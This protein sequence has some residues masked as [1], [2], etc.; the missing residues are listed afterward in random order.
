LRNGKIDFRY[1]DM[2]EKAEFIERQKI[3]NNRVQKYWTATKAKRGLYAQSAAA[4]AAA[5]VK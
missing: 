2:L 3:Q 5:P 1:T 4:T